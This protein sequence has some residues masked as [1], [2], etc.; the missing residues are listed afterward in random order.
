MYL[1]NNIKVAR[2]KNEKKPTT[3]VTVVNTTVLP[4]AGS[5]SIF[6]RNNG[7]IAPKKPAHNKL[8][9]IESAMT[10]PS[11]PLSNHIAAIIPMIIAKMRPFARESITSFF[12]VRNASCWAMSPSAS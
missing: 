2:P 3:S 11:I 5:T 4:I 8:M 9:I 7:T 10:M 12:I 1:Y 6:L